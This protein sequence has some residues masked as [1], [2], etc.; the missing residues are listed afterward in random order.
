MQKGTDY[1]G[2]IDIQILKHG[3]EQIHFHPEA[4]VIYVIAGSLC[5]QLDG[6]KYELQRNDVILINAGLSHC[7]QSND[8]V[9]YCRVLISYKIL[10]D[11]IGDGNYIFYCNSVSDR[12]HSYVG[13]QEIMQRIVYSFAQKQRKTECLRIGLVYELMDL[14]V[15]YFRKDVDNSLP[16]KTQMANEQIQ[17]I[18][19]YVNINFNRSISLRGLAEQMYSSTST[20]SRIFK[21]HTGIY[22]ADYVNQVRLNYAVRELVETDKPITKIAV[23]CGFSNPSVFSKAFAGMYQMSPSA[24][25]KQMLEDKVQQGVADEQEWKEITDEIRLIYKTSDAEHIGEKQ[26]I[27][28]T[29]G[30][31]VPYKK[32]WNIMLNA[33]TAYSLTLANLQYHIIYLSEQLKFE[34]VRIWNIFSTRLMI[35]RTENDYNYNFDMVDNVLDFLVGHGLKPFIDF[36][37]RPDTALAG[38]G[39]TIYYEEENITFQNRRDWERIF[40]AFISHILKRY[41]KEEVEQWIY[42]FSSDAKN[43]RSCLEEESDLLEELYEFGYQEIKRYLPYAKVGGIGAA[44]D[45]DVDKIMDWLTYCKEKG[46][47]PDFV[48]VLGFPYVEII[49]NGKRIAKRNTDTKA[50]LEQIRDFRKTLDDVG[51]EECQLFVT[52]C[53]NTLSNRNYLNDSCYRAAYMMAAVEVLWDIPDILGIW[54]GSDWVSSYYDTVRVANGGSGIITKNGT[55][56]PIFYGLHFLNRLGSKFLK[57]GNNY[58]VTTNGMNSYYILCFHCKEFSPE[59]FFMEEDNLDLK[60]MHE[61]FVDGN[62]MELKIVLDGMPEG[63]IFVVK[64]HTVNDKH[65]SILGE[66]SKFQFEK[67]MESNDEKHLRE[68]CTPNLT[69]EKQT[70]RNEKLVVKARLEA[71]EVALIHVYETYL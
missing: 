46:C 14:L 56:K 35:Q 29:L 19:N 59:Y 36:G 24:Y 27:Q 21:K 58:I 4:E 52:E 61:L 30:N 34:Y 17:T 38:E 16:Q 60:N 70:V 3:M 23:D 64:K 53:N 32:F 63:Q 39:E 11:S 25:R 22:F 5:V 9:L 40:R 2:G 51:M 54:M 50:I 49:E 66:W 69:M 55:R 67:E 8:E 1:L 47:I 57:K 68:I 31:E 10:A 43:G 18:M 65:G 6:K 26:D 41:G 13:V 37:R 33:G 71:N 7:I 12:V 62:S 48:S 42:E 15:E 45:S 44:V 20:L 28:V